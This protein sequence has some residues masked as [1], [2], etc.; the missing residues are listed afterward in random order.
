[1]A[2]ALAANVDAQR[3][4][5][6]NASHQLRTPL[7]G[8]RLRLEAIREEGGEQAEQAAK[9]EAEIDRLAVLVED[10][11]TLAR[12]AS[13]ETT[14]AAVDL[15]DAARE[16]VDRWRGPAEEGRKSVS[17]ESLAEAPIW[18]DP[19][20][21]AHILDNLIE[22][23]VLYTP[24]GTA[25]RVRSGTAGGSSFVEVADDGPGISAEDAARIFERFYRGAS[26]RRVGPGTGL[27]LAIAA[28][29]ARRW[30]GDLELRDGPGVSFVAT[31][32]VKPTVS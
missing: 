11:L 26:G 20:D 18:A 12:A 1:M 29:L 10:L 17:E 16:A 3:D 4:F 8:L 32:P 24:V 2:E 27:G 28:D 7:T 21:M 31:F 9:A 25:I 15:A 14:G 5:L 6:A 22:N 19:A 23:A 13:A 30:G